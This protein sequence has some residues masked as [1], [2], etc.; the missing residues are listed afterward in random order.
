MNNFV[1]QN[2]LLRGSREFPTDSEDLAQEVNKS[3][4]DVATA[5]N[6]RTIGLFPNTRAAITG[7]NWYI[8]GTQKQQTIRE[9]YPIT[10]YAS[11]NH[12]IDTTKIDKF[13]VI[14]GMGY[15]ATAGEYWP[16]PYINGTSATGSVG[17]AVNTTQVTFSAG[18]T[19]PAI[20]SGFVLLEWL[21]PL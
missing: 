18:G 7:E 6:L 21:T 11:F 15:N 4:V 20:Q 17:M 12:N 16:L 10:S 19:A 1:N 5:V 13:S 2:P 3:Y 8:I 14:R 9:V